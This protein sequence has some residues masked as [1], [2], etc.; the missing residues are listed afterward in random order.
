ML[1][2]FLLPAVSKTDPFFLSAAVMAQ[3]LE[4][5]A[6]AAANLSKTK[7]QTN[8][9]P[10]LRFL[11]DVSWGYWNRDN[12]NIRNINWYIIQQVENVDVGKLIARAL[13]NKKKTLSPWSGTSFS[14]DSDEGHAILGMVLLRLLSVLD[15]PAPQKQ[16][17]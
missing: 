2:M 15:R 3:E 4:S 6:Y 10:E 14:M 8:Q 17:C 12:S 11:T 1:P 13:K 16:L 7:P 5:P 9:L